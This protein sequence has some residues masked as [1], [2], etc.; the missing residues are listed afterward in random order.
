MTI[1]GKHQCQLKQPTM[2]PTWTGKTGKHFPVTESPGILIRL[3]SWGIFDKILE[4]LRIF[5]Q[6][7]GKVL[8]YNFLFF[9]VI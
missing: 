2:V 3:K 6:N 9:S 5:T 1:E 8:D 7:T 4:K